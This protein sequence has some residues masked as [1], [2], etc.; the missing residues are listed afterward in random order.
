MISSDPNLITNPT[1]QTFLGEMFDV[2][3]PSP[4]KIHLKD[5]SHALSMICRYGGHSRDFYSVA[6]HCVLLAEYFEKAGDLDLAQFALL[7]DAS[8]AY[9]GDLVRPLKMQLSLYRDVEDQLLVTIFTKFGLQPV[10]PHIVKMADLR[11]T[12]DEREML[13]LSRPWSLDP[14]EPLGVELQCW[15]HDQA[16]QAWLNTYWRL[17]P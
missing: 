9:M 13:M 15:T 5:I 4:E 11:I 8:E 7:H 14:T 6:E 12:T 1:I 3:S 16:E 2:F 17:F 10:A